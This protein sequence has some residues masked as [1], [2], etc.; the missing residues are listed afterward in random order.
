MRVTLPDTDSYNVVIDATTIPTPTADATDRDDSDPDMFILRDGQV[1]ASGLEYDPVNFPNNETFTTQALPAGSDY[2][3]DIHDW[4]FEDVV[5]APAG[6]PDTPN[7]DM[8]F[9][10]TITATP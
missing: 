3:A 5:G 8:C 10:I 1:V 6:Y 2:V 9:D 7:G 4:R